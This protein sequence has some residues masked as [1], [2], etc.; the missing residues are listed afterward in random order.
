MV[1]FFF[2]FSL[3]F[4]LSLFHGSSSL[5]T[6]GITYTSPT[7][8][9]TANP[10]HIASTVTSL[11]FQAVRLP[12]ADPS[13]IR[14]FAY[15]NTSLLLSIPNILVPPLASNRSLALGWLYRHVLPFYPRSRISL[16][17]VG[18]DVFDS[19]PDFSPFLLPAIRNVYLALRDLDI[20]KVPVSTT[21]SFY[22]IITTSFPPSSARFE[23]PA[24]SLILKPLLQFL[25]D[26][27]SSFLVNLYPYNMYR[28][29]N[30]IPLGFALFQDFPFNFRDDLVTGVR[31]KNL[32]DMMADSVVSAMVVAGHVNTPI[33]VAEI[34]WPSSGADSGEVEATRVYVEMYL[35]GLVAHLRSGLGTPLRKEGIAEVYIYELVDKEGKGNRSWGILHQNLTKKYKV[36]FSG[37]FKIG[38][39]GGLLMFVAVHF[40]ILL[41]I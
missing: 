14:A 27:N 16:I 23:E 31:Y 20:N 19:T 8:T 33:I 32:F 35:K 18:N 5:T 38:R 24:G 3:V 28:L 9:T 25:D 37:G 41:C 40:S 34:G 11:N 30:E 4:Q 10:E 17:S 6:I 7:T 29:Y 22:N 2:T 13:I 15:T 36:E 12:G 1:S 26:T 39:F 21:F